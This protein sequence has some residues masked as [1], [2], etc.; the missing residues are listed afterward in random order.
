MTCLEF[1]T[2]GSWTGPRV[3]V[4]YV[5]DVFSRVLVTGGTRH[6][7]ACFSS[8]DLGVNGRQRTDTAHIPRLPF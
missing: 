3:S 7:G 8:Y 6:V 5:N 4:E 1:L 2:L